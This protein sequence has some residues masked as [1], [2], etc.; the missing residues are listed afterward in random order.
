MPSNRLTVATETVSSRTPT[1]HVDGGSLGNFNTV[2]GQALELSL[3]Q[4][5]D[6]YH[7]IIE[8]VVEVCTRAAEGDLEA[9]MLH[10]GKSEKLRIVARSVN[11]MLD[12]TDAFLR[13]AGAAL[14]HASQGKFFRRV[15][16]RGMRGTFRNKSQLI[17]DATDRLGRDTA[18]LNEVERLISTSAQVAQEAMHEA[19]QASAVV[20]QLG[21]S[22]K[23][24]GD[25][26]K[27]ISQ[28]AWQT[29]L[30][31]FNAKIEASHAGEAGRGFEVVAQEVKNL[32]QH[33]ATDTESI[34]REIQGMRREVERTTV[35]MET[36]RKTIEKMQQISVEIQRAV[37]DHNRKASG[38]GRS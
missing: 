17:N 1:S 31:A 34:A 29:K 8:K 27:S 25:V 4:E 21:D 2:G 28:I 20:N 11:H 32:A 22:S 5:L 10:C 23:R 14:D 3:E 24:I 7:E 30:L 13:E 33:T 38:G 15:L 36:V 37:A 12:M 26:T 6:L 16:L 19:A 18:S 35:A 9:R